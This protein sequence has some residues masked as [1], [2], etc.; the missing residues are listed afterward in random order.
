[1]GRTA[2]EELCLPVYLPLLQKFSLRAGVVRQEAWEGGH[3][4]GTSEGVDIGVLSSA[5]TVLSIYIT[6]PIR[7]PG[8]F[9][10][11]TKWPVNVNRVLHLPTRTD[12][13]TQETRSKE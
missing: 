9:P 12:E 7:Q 6:D 1:M 2:P 8:S 10:S 5:V 3:V 4:P 11:E 13:E